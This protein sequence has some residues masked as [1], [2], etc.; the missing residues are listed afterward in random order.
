MRRVLLAI[1]L[2]I[3]LFAAAAY[4]GSNGL[5]EVVTD[6]NKA[7]V[8]GSLVVKG[9]GGAPADP[10]LSLVQKRILAL[11]AA[12]VTALRETAEILNG[13]TVSGETLIENAAAE[14]DT[15]RSTVQGIIKGAQVIKEV[16]D[17]LSELGVVYITVPLTGPNGVLSA[18]LPQVIPMM[19]PGLPP[20]MEAAFQPPAGFALDGNYDGLI[21]DVRGLAFKPA[22]INRVVT[23][24]NSV[25]YDPSGVDTAVL[26]ERG[27]AEYTD[28]IDKA[29]ALLAERGSKNPLVV[30]AE[31]LVRSTD[32]EVGE[33]AAGAISASNQAN[34]F[35]E[36]ARVVFVLQ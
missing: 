31:G 27:A 24:N 16:Y 9:E 20:G 33:D 28:D 1:P 4:A 8:K 14:S 18:L 21:V 22:L 12:K 10:G 32:V 23:R 6:I 34:K 30:K 19:P 17:P 15:V 3:L 5:P 11:R 7:F 25:V 35:L 13:V 29:K 36:S 26:G 2:F